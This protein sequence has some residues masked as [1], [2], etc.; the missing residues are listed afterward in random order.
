MRIDADLVYVLFA[1][2]RQIRVLRVPPPRSIDTSFAAD[3][4]YLSRYRHPFFFVVC[5]SLYE[6]AVSEYVRRPTR[7]ISGRSAE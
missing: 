7:K 1:M 2:I 3:H 4:G 5:I 6:L